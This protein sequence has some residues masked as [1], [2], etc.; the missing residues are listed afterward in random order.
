M[1]LALLAAVTAQPAAPVAAERPA[2]VT[3]R[4]MR[5]AEIRQDRLEATEES[6]KRTTSVR[7]SDGTLRAASLIEF[8]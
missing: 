2:T 6:V 4:I 5:A 8:Y 7:E 1:L 3:V